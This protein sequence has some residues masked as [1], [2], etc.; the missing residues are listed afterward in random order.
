MDPPSSAIFP[1]QPQ[2]RAG[3]KEN[4]CNH[5]LG[6]MFILWTWSC[7]LIF[8]VLCPPTP[9]SETKTILRNIFFME[10]SPCLTPRLIPFSISLFS[11]ERYRSLSTP[12]HSVAQPSVLEASTV[13][14]ENS[15]LVY[16]PPQHTSP[17]STQMVCLHKL[18][19][20][21]LS[22]ILPVFF[23]PPYL[24]F[25][26]SLSL[27]PSLF[28]LLD[29]LYNLSS[30]VHQHLPKISQLWHLPKICHIYISTCVQKHL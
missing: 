16:V 15:H 4:W 27:F 5:P 12:F 26:S 8:M 20:L 22:L 21:S 14:W 6:F 30:A 9:P 25:F 23:L 2:K 19:P 7:S 28:L 11:I 24:L 29:I 10:S 18:Y 13:V 3:L 1:D 17:S